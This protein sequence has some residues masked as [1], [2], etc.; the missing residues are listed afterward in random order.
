V[1][2]YLF[3]RTKTKG[4]T[5]GDPHAAVAV[6]FLGDPTI[7][8]PFEQ[9]PRPKQRKQVG[10][11]LRV[12]AGGLVLVEQALDEI[13]CVMPVHRDVRCQRDV[14]R[15]DHQQ[16]IHACRAQPPHRG[17]QTRNCATGLG[18]WPQHRADPQAMHRPALQREERDKTLA[19]WWQRDVLITAVYCES[20]EYVERQLFRHTSIVG[21]R[22]LMDTRS[23]LPV[24]R[25]LPTYMPRMPLSR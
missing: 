9:F 22:D 17:A 19:G 4:V 18:M 1:V 15:I 7:G 3:L 25:A 10:D 5:R 23:A 2:A 6:T 12:G 20:A 13:H 8:P 24:F 21:R 11:E 16:L 14:L